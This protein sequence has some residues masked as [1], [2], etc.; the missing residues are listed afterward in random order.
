[1]MPYRDKVLRISKE[2]GVEHRGH[3]IDVEVKHDDKCPALNGQECTCD[4]DVIGL[5][6]TCDVYGRIV[7]P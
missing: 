7:D 3:L 4:A 5:C 1:M 2:M 6:L